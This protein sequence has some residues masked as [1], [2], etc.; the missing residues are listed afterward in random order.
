MIITYTASTQGLNLTCTNYTEDP[1]SSGGEVSGVKRGA[2]KSGGLRS[3]D[4]KGSSKGSANPV[5]KAGKQAKN[6]L[7]SQGKGNYLLF[8]KVKR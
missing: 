8:I 3:E 2:C 7:D 4:D 5:K 1:K 6:D